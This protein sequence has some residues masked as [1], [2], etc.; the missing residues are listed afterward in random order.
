MLRFIGVFTFLL[1]VSVQMAEVFAWDLQIGYQR[2]LPKLGTG[3]QEY[4][5]I[6]GDKIKFKPRVEVTILGQSFS[7]GLKID[8]YL[9]RYEYSEFNYETTIPALHPA[10]TSDTVAQ[11]KTTER[12]LGL[13]YHI[14]RELAGIFV[15]VGLS[16]VEERLSSDTTEWF[17][18]TFTPYLKYGFDLMVLD[19]WRI[20][21][22]QMHAKHGEHTVK[23]NSM[24]IVL[25]F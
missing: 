18:S 11:C 24:G 23:I 7:L 8:S 13:S 10:V 2:L 5:S 4:E 21:T 6:A 9:V 14:E 20:R 15:G 25:V 16:S 17:F 12:R 1:I 3:E 19:S 22:E